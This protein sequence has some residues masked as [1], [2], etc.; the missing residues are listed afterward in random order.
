MAVAKKKTAPKKKAVATKG[1]WT[2]PWAKKGAITEKK[3]GE[4]YKSK[5]EMVK[6]EKGETKKVRAAEGEI[7][8]MKKGG[9]AKDPRKPGE[10]RPLTAAELMAMQKQNPEIKKA[11]VKKYQTSIPEGYEFGKTSMDSVTATNMGMPLK[12][13]NVVKKNGVIVGNRKKPATSTGDAMDIMKKGGKTT[14]KKKVAT[15]K[16]GGKK[17]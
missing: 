9:A 3:T 17:C 7:P 12:H 14:A 16:K 1:A 13:F 4:K 15:Y 11:I 2:P 8:K 6:H 5:A 10:K